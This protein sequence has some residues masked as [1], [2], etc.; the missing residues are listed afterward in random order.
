[1]SQWNAGWRSD[2]AVAELTSTYTFQFR[3]SKGCCM[4]LRR[5]HISTAVSAAGTQHVAS[6]RANLKL[7]L[8]A[9]GFGAEAPRPAASVTASRQLQAR[10][11]AATVVAATAAWFGGH[12]FVLLSP[13]PNS[14]VRG[15]AVI[16]GGVLQ[17]GRAYEPTEDR[18]REPTTTRSGIEGVTPDH[19]LR[20]SFTK[21]RS[22][23]R[24]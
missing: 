8:A 18:H 23:D 6:A 13:T 1:M 15:V 4:R 2:F 19:P 12:T 14:T 22:G 9:P 3:C 21:D 17:L 24:G 20:G 5:A 16:E 10:L 11:A 7:K